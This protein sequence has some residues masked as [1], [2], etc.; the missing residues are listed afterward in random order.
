MTSIKEIINQFTAD[1]LNNYSLSAPVD[2]LWKKFKQMCLSCLSHIPTR[3]F[4][5]Q[6]KKLWMTARI[7]RMSCKKT[8]FV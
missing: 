8:T 6:T 3:Q 2:N 7:K 4:S 5:T 1:F